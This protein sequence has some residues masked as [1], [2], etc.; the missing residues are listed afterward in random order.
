LRKIE[1]E[2]QD[3][4]EI[5]VIVRQAAGEN[6][7]GDEFT[8]NQAIRLGLLAV[9]DVESDA[10]PHDSAVFQLIRRRIQLD[11]TDLATRRAQAQFDGEIGEVAVGF[12]LGR[13]PRRVVLLQHLRGEDAAV[14]EHVLGSES[15]NRPGAGA[16]EGKSCGFS[17]GTLHLIDVAVGQIVADAL[18][19]SVHFT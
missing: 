16:D 2:Q 6:T 8:A 15:V 13:R 17:D 19:A 7:G 1:I 11:P 12:L 3:L 9:G 14:A 5:V 10:V 4:Q 18:Q